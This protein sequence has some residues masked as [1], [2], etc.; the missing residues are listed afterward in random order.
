MNFVLLLG[1]EELMPPYAVTRRRFLE[2]A[3][4][5]VAGAAAVLPGRWHFSVVCGHDI[6]GKAQTLAVAKTPKTRAPT[7]GRLPLQIDL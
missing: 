5:S 2:S 1:E 7:N 3:T 6:C 4:L